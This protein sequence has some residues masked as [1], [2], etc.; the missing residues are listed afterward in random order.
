MS[1]NEFLKQEKLVM[2][3]IFGDGEQV[4]LGSLSRSMYRQFLE[5]QTKTIRFVA[6]GGEC[7]IFKAE[8]WD[9]KQLADP[10]DMLGAQAMALTPTPEL[11]QE[12]ERQ[13]QLRKLEA[14]LDE[15]RR[16]GLSKLDTQSLLAINNKLNALTP[17][18][19]LQ[20][21]QCPHC[22]FMMNS[23][24][25]DFSTDFFDPDGGDHDCPSCSNSFQFTPHVRWLWECTEVQV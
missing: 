19:H 21:P 9:G 8:H 7:F 13:D 5:G 2:K 16:Q 15:I 22:G 6:S 24:S 11:I 3:R 14:K 25:E 20:H 12:S 18:S 23:E 17:E 1:L 4:Y 10:R